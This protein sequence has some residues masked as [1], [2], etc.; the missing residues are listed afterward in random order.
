MVYIHVLQFLSHADDQIMPSLSYF[1][2]YEEALDAAL[3]KFNNVLGGQGFEEQTDLDT[4]AQMCCDLNFAFYEIE[5]FELGI[6][7]G[8]GG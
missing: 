3:A 4:A 6:H 7:F 8:F 5:T 1:Q 2:Y